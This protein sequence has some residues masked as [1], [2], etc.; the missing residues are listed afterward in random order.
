MP[1]SSQTS[2]R[3]RNGSAAIRKRQVTQDLRFDARAIRETQ[4]YG[5]GNRTYGG[6]TYTIGASY[7][8]GAGTL[9]MYSMYP[10][11]P[12]KSTRLSEYHLTQI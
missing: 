3:R 9:L 1:L 12:S 8:S 4:S 2:L 11:E 6:S 7:N 10:I 5:H